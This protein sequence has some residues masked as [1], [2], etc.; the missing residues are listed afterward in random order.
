VQ[1]GEQSSLSDIEA[2]EFFSTPA[3][4]GSYELGPTI[5]IFIQDVGYAKFRSPSRV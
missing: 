3:G 1:K 5:V 4:F 2:S